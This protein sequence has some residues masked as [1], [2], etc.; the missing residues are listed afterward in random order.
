MIHN[1]GTFP[2][3]KGNPTMNYCIM[4]EDEVRERIHLMN[5]KRGTESWPP[6]EAYIGERAASITKG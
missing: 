4:P 6:H 3:I 1:N 5:A 2:A